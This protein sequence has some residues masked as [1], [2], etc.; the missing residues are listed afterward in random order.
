MTRGS[1]DAVPAL[2]DTLRASL[3]EHVGALLRD[4]DVSSIDLDEGR[5]IVVTRRARREELAA[6]IPDAL[7][8]AFDA[9]GAFAAHASSDAVFMATLP[10]GDLVTCAR[11]GESRRVHVARAPSEPVYMRALL[12]EGAIDDDTAQGLMAAIEN[13]RHVVVAGPCASGR[14]RLA[15][16]LATECAPYLSV[17]RLGAHGPRTLA[18]APEASSTSTIPAAAAALGVEL[19]L[20]LDVDVPTLRSLLEG[21]PPVVVVASAR[22]PRVP[23]G[24]G[25]VERA[26][27]RFSSTG[28]ALVV[29]PVARAVEVEPA[30][31]ATTARAAPQTVVEGFAPLPTLAPGP[32]SG[33]ASR[34]HDAEPGWELSS[35][36]GDVD[37][38]SAFDD[39]LARVKDKR[40][41]YAPR[42]PEAHPAARRLRGLGG[43]TLESPGGDAPDDDT[44]RDDD[45]A[46]LTRPE[47]ER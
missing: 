16:A 19:L 2:D 13:G 26:T 12:E 38:R 10:S 22:T 18:R 37:D 5:P 39:V 40:A 4:A 17:A 21:D 47:E 11:M 44:A 1:R 34:A 23:D 45:E 3:D 8:T 32:P 6:S 24:I 41:P 36:E 43:L 29:R 14:T 20:A 46:A 35:N 33:W 28:A 31:R 30:P 9:V 27:V 25:D 42:P 15:I 7:F